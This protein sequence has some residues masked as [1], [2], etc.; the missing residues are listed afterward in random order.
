MDDALAADLVAD[1]LRSAWIV[2]RARSLLYERWS[3]SDGRFTGAAERARR[4]AAIVAAAVAARGRRTDD[5]L[6][7][8]HAGWIESLAGA[9][10][11]AVPLGDAL[12]VRLADWVDAHAGEFLPADRDELAALLD[13]DRSEVSFPERWPGAPGFEP[14]PPI[15]PDPPGPTLLRFGI[16]GDLHIGSAGARRMT[17]AAISDLNASGAELVV[18]LG[19]ITN[20]G[21]RAEFELAT[22][23]LSKLEMPCHTMLGN[24]DVFSITERRLSGREYY[25]GVFGRTPD[26]ALIEHRGVRFA[27]LDS[28]DNAASPFAPFDLVTGTFSQGPGGAI[29][30]GAL[31]PPQHD[32]LAEIAVPGSPPAF[33]FLH[34]PVQPFTGFPPVV[35]GLRDADSGRLHATVDSGNVWGVFAGHTHRNAITRTFDGVPAVEVGIPR[36]FPFGYALV[37]VSEHGYAYSFRQVSDAELLGR[38]YERTGELH[39]R[40]G[41]GPPEARGFVWPRPGRDDT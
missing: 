28:A 16:L 35:F 29:V 10:P 39:R 31:T 14:L 33:V 5:D 21:E 18:Q 15:A 36:D 2:E 19:D 4:R 8:A 22:R 37:D 6:A 3:G 24:H 25:P 9:A 34:H 20:H 17:L 41:L 12:V 32:I 11:G 1:L 26:G 40:Y 13:H 7:P 30:R 38:A 23:L 27:I